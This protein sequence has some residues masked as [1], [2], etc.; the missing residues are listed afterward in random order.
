M[1][2]I[3]RRHVKTQLVRRVPLQARRH[4]HHLATQQVIGQQHTPQL[5]PYSRRFLATQRQFVLLQAVFHL[6]IPQFDFPAMT[7]ELYDVCAWEA[8]RVD[9]RGQHLSRLAVDGSGQ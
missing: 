3:H 6:P 2:E 9:H 8:H 4:L 7:I 5:L 1:D